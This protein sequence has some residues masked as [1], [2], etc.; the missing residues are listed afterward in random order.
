MN[1]NIAFKVSSLKPSQLT[2]CLSFRIGRSPHESALVPHSCS[3]DDWSDDEDET[4]QTPLDNIDPF[5]MLADTLAG[6]QALS[7][8]RHQ[9]IVGGSDAGVQAALQALLVHSVTQRQ[10]ISRLAGQL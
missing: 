10:K 3:D 5:V 8:A 9:A 1:K 6:I 4:L 2:Q 7:P